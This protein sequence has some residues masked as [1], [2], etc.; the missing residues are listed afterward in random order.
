ML[1]RLTV[2]AKDLRL[3]IRDRS[4]ILI[5]VVA[6]FLLASIVGPALGGVGRFSTKLAFSSSP[7]SASVGSSP[8]ERAH[9]RIQVWK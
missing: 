6:P 2:A 3:R 1:A 7:A 4:L 5:G 8:C 9:G